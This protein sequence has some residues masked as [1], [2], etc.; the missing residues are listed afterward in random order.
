MIFDIIEYS[1]K[2]NIPGKGE[3]VMVILSLNYDN[4]YYDASFVYDSKNFVTLT[5]DESLEDEIG[6]IEHWAGY[7]QLIMDIKSKIIS[8]DEIIVRLDEIDISGYKINNDK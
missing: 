1:G 8:Y 6:I 4:N 5:V 2:I 3:V 7:N